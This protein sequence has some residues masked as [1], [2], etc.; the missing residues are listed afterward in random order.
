VV[1]C[2]PVHQYVV[3]EAA[4]FVQESGILDLAHI[5]ARGIVRR[6]EIDEL[7]RLATCNIDFAHVTYI[8]Q[9]HAL[10]NGAML[11][12]DA[13]ILHRHIPSAEVDHSSA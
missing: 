3:N 2:D 6:D 11:F 4:M 1:F 10:P 7:G 13:R 8:E 5:E 12:E 9:A